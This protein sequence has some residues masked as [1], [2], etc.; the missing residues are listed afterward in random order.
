MS[1]TRKQRFSPRSKNLNESGNRTAR[2][3]GCSE[4]RYIPPV[5]LEQRLAALE[6]T[7]LPKPEPEP[8]SYDSYIELSKSLGNAEH[9]L[10]GPLTL[11]NGELNPDMTALVPMPDHCISREQYEAMTWSRAEQCCKW[12]SDRCSMYGSNSVCLFMSGRVSGDTMTTKQQRS[13]LA[14]TFEGFDLSDIA[15]K[16]EM[17]TTDF[18]VHVIETVNCWRSIAG[19]S[20]SLIPL[21]G[22]TSS[23]D[24][25][26]VERFKDRQANHVQH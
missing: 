4:R 26:D 13:A 3:R 24:A 6:A 7:L 16:F 8:F 17:L 20:A 15:P 18:V 5:R 25:D 14:T 19:K 2:K 21:W 10:M 22:Q 11:P 23:I 12:V 1:L 9:P